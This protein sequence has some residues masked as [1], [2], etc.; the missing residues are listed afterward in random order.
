MCIRDRVDGTY[1]LTSPAEE[2]PIGSQVVL[3]PKNDWMHL[4]EMCIRD[5]DTGRNGYQR[6]REKGFEE[7]GTPDQQK[8]P[9]DHARQEDTYGTFG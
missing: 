5:R 1:E 8:D 2:R 3:H 6:H 4:F 9:G 7:T